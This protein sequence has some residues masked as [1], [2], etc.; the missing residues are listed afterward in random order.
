[1][2]T[3]VLFIYSTTLM[4]IMPISSLETVFLLI[5]NIFMRYVHYN[6]FI[7]GYRG[8]V[9]IKY[10]PITQAFGRLN[11]LHRNFVGIQSSYPHVFSETI[12]TEEKYIEDLVHGCGISSA[13]VM[14]ILQSCKL[15]P[16]W[17][18]CNI[19]AEKTYSLGLTWYFYLRSRLI[20]YDIFE[21]EMGVY[22]ESCTACFN[23]NIELLSDI[24][25]NV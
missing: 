25:S 14:E 5:H 2:Y 1:M 6:N 15:P 7:W 13:L 17:N 10:T 24:I 8:F 23:W 22:L 18:I 4:T 20:V 19:L 12:Q 16:A 21:R 11:M 3:H 9:W